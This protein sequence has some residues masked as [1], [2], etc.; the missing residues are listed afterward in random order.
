MVKAQVLAG[1]RGKG[2]FTNGFQGGVHA[3]SSSQEVEE[4]ASKM[5]GNKIITKQTGAAGKICNQVLVVERLMCDKETYFAIMMDRG[6][7]TP[8]I[9][10][11]SEGGV[12]IET[13]AKTNPDAIVTMPVDIIT[14][15][16]EDMAKEL[17]SKMKF[18]PEAQP[19]AQQLILNMWKTFVGADAT[20]VE[21]NPLSETKDHNVLAMDAKLGFD[22]NADF[23]QKGIFEMRDKS[24]EDPDEVLASS[25]GL[26]FIKLDGTIGCLV[27]GAGLAMATMDIIKLYGGEPANFLD[28]GGT[29]NPDSIKEAFGLILNDPKISAIFVNIFGGIVRCDD[30][31]KGLVGVVKDSN[32]KVPIVARIQGTNEAEARKILSDSKMKIFSIPD[33]D[34]AAEKVCQVSK[35]YQDAHKYEHSFRICFR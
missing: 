20:Q 25:Y 30:I 24:Q 17:A 18:S 33:L 35:E 14:G 12:D 15:V 3:A 1:G 31:A 2:K 9:V 32:I 7:Q 26:N 27:N 19:R 22:D 34:Q 28:V 6:R 10:A 11:S 23:R 5:L 21:I 8:M 16:T 13:T 4:L 29:A